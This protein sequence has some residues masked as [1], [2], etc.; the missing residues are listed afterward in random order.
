MADC[1]LTSWLLL[2]NPWKIWSSASTCAPLIEAIST[3]WHCT[4][5]CSRRAVLDGFSLRAS[6]CDYSVQVLTLQEGAGNIRR[7]YCVKVSPVLKQAERVE[8]S[9]ATSL[10]RA[11]Q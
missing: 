11:S 2:R 4:P 6:R 10:P 9:V 7:T 5:R 1:N 3:R 8:C